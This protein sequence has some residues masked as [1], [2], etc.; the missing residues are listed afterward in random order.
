MR[1]AGEDTARRPFSLPFNTRP[2][3]QQSPAAA[4]CVES[5][6]RGRTDADAK[7]M[8]KGWFWGS[9]GLGAGFGV[10]GVGAAPATAAM[11]KPK[12]KVIPP[13]VD[14]ACYTQGFGSK[15]RNEHALTALWGSLVG[16]GI[17]LVSY[18]VSQAFD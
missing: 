9:V 13:G 11:F 18:G 4:P 3:F 17:W 2:L 7:P 5:E 10:F 14:A 15:G 8:H 6:A 12:P 1:L 16:M